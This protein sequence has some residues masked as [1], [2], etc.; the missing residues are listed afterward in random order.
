MILAIKFLDKNYQR[1]I[2][3]SLNMP[4]TRPELTWWM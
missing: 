1:N 4:L 3:I 2:F